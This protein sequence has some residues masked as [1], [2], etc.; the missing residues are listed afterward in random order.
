MPVIKY[1]KPETYDF[2][3]DEYE[4]ALSEGQLEEIAAKNGSSD[5]EFDDMPISEDE[6]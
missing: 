6:E 3:K 5:Q 1:I 4:V 2:L